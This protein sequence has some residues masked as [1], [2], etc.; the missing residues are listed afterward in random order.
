M[1]DDQTQTQLAVAALKDASLIAIGLTALCEFAWVLHTSY[2]FSRS[3]V[4]LAIRSLL[5]IDSV[6]VH[7]AAVEAGLAMLDAGG[8]FADGVV[9]YEGAWLGGDVFVS[10]DKKAIERLQKQGREV[11][12]LA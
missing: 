2:D 1:R 7:R 4:A 10:F 3:D 12:L 11:Q 6:S 8:D 5:H 9:A